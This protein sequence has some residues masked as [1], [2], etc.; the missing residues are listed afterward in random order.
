MKDLIIQG[1]SESIEKEMPF[2]ILRGNDDE[3]RFAGD[4][5]IL[6]PKGEANRACL[7]S[8]SFFC[9]KGWKLL[10]YRDIGYLSTITLT[11]ITSDS[12]TAIK[13]D[14]FSGLE[15]YGIGSGRISRKFFGEILPSCV[16]RDR[17]NELISLV[18]YLQKCMYVG[19][20]SD[21]DQRR[22]N[23]KPEILVSIAKKIEL[24]V[25]TGDAL[26]GMG[27]LSQWRL[28]YESSGVRSPFELAEW[29]IN[30]LFAAIR[31]RLKK[32][33]YSGMIFELSGMDGSGK[34]TQLKLLRGIYEASGGP[35][36]AFI[37]FLPSWIMTPHQIFRRSV[38][39]E[40]YM[41]PYSEPPTSS[42]VSAFLRI[43]WYL[44]SFT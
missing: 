6:V 26:K 44:I 33:I 2:L 1:V 17:K 13:V 25:S 31:S 32:G 4:I 36:P 9:L 22:I 30:V 19:K 23:I 35:M 27:K 8:S 10:S 38:T 21:R 7:L 42:K 18:N 15:W 3:A 5:D 16:D 29:C 24:H 20:L 39:K 37:H 14:F 11:L 34:S 43:C 40:N 41:N 28:R 12:N